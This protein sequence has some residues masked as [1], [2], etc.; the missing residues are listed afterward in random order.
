MAEIITCP[1]CQRKLQ[2]PV[3]YYGQTV[4]CPECAH[5]FVADP[6]AQGVQTKTPSA[7]PSANEDRPRSRARD[8]DDEHD[9][10]DVKKP[11]SRRSENPHRGGL[12]LALGIVSLVVFFPCSIFC[13]PMAWSMGN[14]DLAEMRTGNMDPSGEG[15]VQA[16]RVL[17]MIATNLMIAVVVLICLFVGFVTVVKGH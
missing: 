6:H 2:V 15:M 11:S 1:D 13:G 16:G 5:T 7:A 14:A 17:G 12:I 3:S 8:R 10:I 9:D 4:Q